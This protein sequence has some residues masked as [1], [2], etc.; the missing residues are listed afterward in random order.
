MIVIKYLIKLMRAFSGSKAHAAQLGV[1][2]RLTRLA[3]PGTIIR[4]K[5]HE[6]VIN[7]VM[8]VS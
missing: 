3:L 8:A 5:H 6:S 1:A 4:R 7:I 2:P